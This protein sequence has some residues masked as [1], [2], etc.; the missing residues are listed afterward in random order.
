M[1]ICEAARSNGT[2][3]ALAAQD[4]GIEPFSG[5]RRPVSCA[6]P[7][8]RQLAR[9]QRLAQPVLDCDGGA[10]PGALHG[11]ERAPARERRSHSAAVVEQALERVG[12]RDRVGAASSIG[13]SAPKTPS[14]LRPASSTHGSPQ[15]S[16]SCGISE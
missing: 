3:R 8:L 11:D 14:T 1:A 13:P 12:E 2:A 16:I 6:V 10:V 7:R 9:P 15:A 5:G 4:W